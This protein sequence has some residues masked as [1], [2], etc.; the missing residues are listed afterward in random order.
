MTY[1]TS[2]IHIIATTNMT[3]LDGVR[4][5]ASISPSTFP[6][7]PLRHCPH[8][9]CRALAYGLPRAPRAKLEIRHGMI[10]CR[11]YRTFS[12]KYRIIQPRPQSFKTLLSTLGLGKRFTCPLFPLCCTG[13]VKQIRMEVCSAPEG[14]PKNSYLKD[15]CRSVAIDGVVLEVLY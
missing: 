2:A 7:W 8:G 3:A 11:H 5:F 1:S 14:V 6:I 4:T 12:S 10:Q 13:T 9:Y 15:S